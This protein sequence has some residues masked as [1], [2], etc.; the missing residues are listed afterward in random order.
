MNLNGFSQTLGTLSG[1]GPAG[2]N[3]AL[4]SGTLTLANAGNMTYSGAISGGAGRL[5]QLGAGMTTLTGNN[6]Y[7]RRNHVTAGTLNFTGNNTLGNG[8]IN[9]NGGVLASSGPLT[10]GPASRPW[11]MRPERPC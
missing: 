10:T 3:V 5:I 1:G 9:I 4:G 8:A 6:S 2:G 11:A 7:T